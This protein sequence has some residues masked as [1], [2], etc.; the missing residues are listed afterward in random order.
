MPRGDDGYAV[1]YGLV[2]R[3]TVSPNDQPSPAAGRHLKACH[4]CPVRLVSFKLKIGDVSVKYDYPPLMSAW[5]VARKD[6]VPC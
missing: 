4:S 3:R 5:R 6:V 1:E 2:V